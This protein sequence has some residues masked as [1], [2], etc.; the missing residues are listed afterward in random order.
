MPNQGRR[1]LVAL[2]GGAATGL[3]SVSSAEPQAPPKV[4]IDDTG[5][6]R[7]RLAATLRELNDVAGLG[8]TKE[9]LDA[10][11]AYATGALLESEAKLRP[12]VLLQ[13]LDLPVVFKARRRG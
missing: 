11:E 12:L 9:D 3:G 5:E 13:G 10:A 7:R 2:L 6:R 1:R 8:V 4:S